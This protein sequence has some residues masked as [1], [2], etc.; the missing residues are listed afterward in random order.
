[1]NHSRRLLTDGGRSGDQSNEEE[2]AEPDPRLNE[3]Y[4]IETG[5]QLSI[6][7]IKSPLYTCA[8]AVF[9]SGFVP[10]A[11]VRV[12]ADG[13][14]I[15]RETPHLGYAKI[16]LDRPL[17][18]GETVTATQE[19]NG[20]ESAESLGVTVQEFDG[21]LP[22]PVIKHDPIECG[23]IVNVGNAVSSARIEVFENGSK[24]GEEA[25]AG[26]FESVN[27]WPA[28]FSRGATV[29]ARLVR[30]TDGPGDEVTGQKSKP[31]T[32]QP[33]PSPVTAPNVEPPTV[34]NDTITLNG[35]YLGADVDIRD[36]GNRIGGGWATASRNWW[37]VEPPVSSNSEYTATQE[38]CDTS[39]S[40][41]KTPSE[42]RQL[43]AP[44]IK[45]P[46]C[47]GTQYV[48]IA[49]T[50]IN[51]RVVLFV[52]G[53]I[54]GYG[55]AVSGELI[56]GV[57]GGNALQPGQTVEAV[58]YMGSNVSPRSNSVTVIQG[59]PSSPD[60][61]VQGGQQLIDPETQEPFE[62]FVRETASGVTVR[63][64]TCCEDGGVAVFIGPNGNELARVELREVYPGYHE[65]EWDWTSE[66][67]GGSSLRPGEYTV[68][69]DTN[70]EQSPAEA[71]FRVVIGRPNRSDASP[72]N[73]RFMANVNGTN[74][75]LTDADQD[76]ITTSLETSGNIDINTTVVG[77]DADGIKRTEL[78]HSGIPSSATVNGRTV[79]Q[80][81][82]RAPIPTQLSVDPSIRNVE[83]PAT[84]VLRGE[85]E[86]FGGS[87]QNSRS[88]PELRVS[89]EKPP[90]PPSVW[91]Q[92]DPNQIY[93]PPWST[94]LLKWSASNANQV[95]ID[96]GIGQ[97][98]DS[99]SKRVDPNADTTYRIVAT[100]PGGQASDTATVRV[101]DRISR[102]TNLGLVH[103]AQASANNRNVEVFQQQN[104]TA[105]VSG[106]DAKLA[107]GR[108]S[109]DPEITG[110][111]NPLG[112]RIVVGHEAPNGIVNTTN[113]LP[114]NGT[115]NALN[116]MSYQGLWEV[117]TDP[118]QTPPGSISIQVSWVLQF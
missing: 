116:G 57:G 54:A 72:P 36:R 100:G 103:D 92:A 16:E 56:L 43:Q 118:M 107:I 90:Q 49:N 104:P 64:A 4:Q 99:G 6:P 46:I 37:P 42:D 102:T 73:V 8:Q 50:T 81:A 70:C 71:R 91:L 85:A 22:T 101:Q 84:V 40:S 59:L 58:Q 33:E 112:I 21:D 110:V 61:T 15:G 55:G 45:T 38:L 83:P 78:I 9:V 106:S 39:P 65:A 31:A 114:S 117:Y 69:V 89:V 96:Q 62:G 11:L 28:T 82:P 51:A 19:V 32:V 86:N 66:E 93:S 98:S 10:G 34:G 35:L 113:I 47:P 3:E 67:G 52:D 41:D 17:K 79:I 29:R 12:F 48:R 2:E 24:V 5:E 63:T 18:Q 80:S 30:C 25:T 95:R 105:Y 60:V 7:Y 44:R 26:E 94:A 20:K 88:T 13:T 23:H 108:S 74:Y 109:Q 111:V 68:R 115:S 75:T 76:A 77:R 97:V 27:I 87:Q 14:E 1:M 53:Q